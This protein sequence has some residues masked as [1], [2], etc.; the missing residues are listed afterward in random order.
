MQDYLQYLERLGRTA[1]T[2]ARAAPAALRCACE[3]FGPGRLMLGP[4]WPY[5][6]GPPF[7]RCVTYIQEAGRPAKGVEAI[8]E[9]NARDLL[10][11]N[12]R[13][14]RR[15]GVPRPAERRGWA[16]WKPKD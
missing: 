15:A 13:A 9:R 2:R 4:G 7:T 8:L 6:V 14:R 3:A 1:R 10:G 5:L 16:P 12:A 11:I